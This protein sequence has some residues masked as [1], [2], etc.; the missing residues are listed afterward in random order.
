MINPG[1]HSSAFLVHR[2]WLCVAVLRAWRH[3]NFFCVLT[4]IVM[5]NVSIFHQFRSCFG[6]CVQSNLQIRLLGLLCCCPHRLRMKYWCLCRI[7][8]LRSLECLSLLILF[9][10][11]VESNHSALCG[12][13]HFGCSF[14]VVHVPVPYVI[15]GATTATNKCSRCSRSVEDSDVSS[16]RCLAN[17]D[18]PHRSLHERDHMSQILYFSFGKKYLDV[19][20]VDLDFSHSACFLV[21]H[22][23]CFVWVD[24][25]SSRFVFFCC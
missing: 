14:V 23:F 24:F 19:H 16:C 7:L 18:Q 2:S 10:F 12:A 9:Y 13:V 1:F 25:E 21:C 22:D 8:R 11:V 5:L 15:V 3:F 20:L 4:Q 17:A 6:L